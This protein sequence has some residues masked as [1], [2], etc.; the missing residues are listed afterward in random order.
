V[1]IFNA[2][3]AVKIDRERI[4]LLYKAERSTMN[5]TPRPLYA[6]LLGVALTA[7]MYA[8]AAEPGFY[9]GGQYGV[10]NK[11]ESP[12]ALN[13]LT[14]NLYRELDYVPDVRLNRFESNDTAWGFLAG[15]Q[16]F[17]NLAFEGGYL[18]VGKDVLRET[19]S[20][21]FLGDT[22]AES[23]STS[24]GVRST[25]FAIS[26]VGI[27]PITYNWELFAR[28]GVY[29]ASN[30]LSFYFVNQDGFGDAGEATE[31]SADMLAGAGAAWTLAEVYQLRAEYTRIFDAGAEEYGET[32]VDLMTIGI[33]VRF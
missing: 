7:P 20:G 2:L 16:L 12:D 14:V 1:R 8:H 13:A 28:G 29:L 18:S 6:V 11:D 22:S 33:T 21:V 26:A 5:T 31:S 23:W 25:G 4:Q 17:T 3:C 27:L 24:L 30:T 10:S 15:Y 9:V 32:D 19:S